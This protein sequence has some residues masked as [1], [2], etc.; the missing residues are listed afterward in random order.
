MQIGSL[1][2]FYKHLMYSLLISFP[3]YQNDYLKDTIYL[4]HGT[5]IQY[6]ENRIFLS[7]PGTGVPQAI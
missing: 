5:N 1:Y 4:Y 7:V 6:Y 3:F 2:Q